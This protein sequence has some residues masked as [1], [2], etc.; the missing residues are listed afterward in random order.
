MQGQRHS[1]E[2]QKVRDYARWVPVIDK[3]WFLGIVVTPDGSL[4]SHVA[5]LKRKARGVAYKF[6]NEFMSDELSFRT[7]LD[8]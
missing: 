4:K 3:F 2:C 1:R 8:I 5:D 7:K 6:K